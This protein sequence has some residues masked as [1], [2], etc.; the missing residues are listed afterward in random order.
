MIQLYGL[1]TVVMS[2]ERAAEPRASME[3][4]VLVVDDDP[5]TVDWLKTVISQASRV[6]RYRVSHRRTPGSGRSRPAA[7]WQPEVVLLDLVLPDVDGI[8][9]L[10]AAEG[11]STRAPR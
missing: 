10:R 7:S 6:P 5:A 11:A 8:D 4:T 1:K 2:T 3:S 9:L